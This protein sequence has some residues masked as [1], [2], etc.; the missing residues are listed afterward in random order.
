MNY[1]FDSYAIIEIFQ[2][3]PAYLVYGNEPVITTAAN[4]A[5]VKQCMLRKGQAEA[6]RPAIHKLN[7]EILDAALNDWETA[8]DFRFSQRGKRISLIDALGYRLAQKHGLRF[9]TGDSKFEKL[10][11]VEFVK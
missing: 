2:G 10:P 6:Y 4:L 8:A 7:P 9:L 11:D 3:N 1:F 5:E